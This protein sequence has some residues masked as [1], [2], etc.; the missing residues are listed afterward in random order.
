LQG[1]QIENTGAN[2]FN[3]FVLHDLKDADYIIC[4]LLK[5]IT[6]SP[7][8]YLFE[9]AISLAIED[10]RNRESS[11]EVLF[12]KAREYKPKLLRKDLELNMVLGRSLLEAIATGCEEVLTST[13]IQLFGGTD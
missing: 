4:I 5:E 3:Y 10:N 6:A 12:I 7:L 13:E 11:P 2:V 9:Y 1:G 8:Q